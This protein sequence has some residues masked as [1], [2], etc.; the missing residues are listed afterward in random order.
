[1]ALFIPENF[2][3]P[4]WPLETSIR[5]FVLALTVGCIIFTTFV[6]ATS[7]PTFL[8]KFR[9]TDPTDIET[10]DYSQ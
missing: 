9:I 1:M 2:T 10:I 8:K 5:D 6:K 7:I 3:L 4:N